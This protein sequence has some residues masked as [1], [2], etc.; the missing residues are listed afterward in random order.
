VR[1]YLLK[2]ADVLRGD[3]RLVG[4]RADERNLLFGERLYA[5]T[6]NREHAN[7]VLLAE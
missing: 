5:R 2:E 3:D 4:E 6:C 7:N 1:S